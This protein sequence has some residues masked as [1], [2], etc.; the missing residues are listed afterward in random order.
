MPIDPDGGGTWIGVNSSGWTYALLNNYQG[1]IPDGKLTSRGSIVSRVLQYR[2]IE[3]IAPLLGSLPLMEFAPFSLLCLAPP[4]TPI[5]DKPEEQN[6]DGNVLRW[7][8]D[9]QRLQRAVAHR[10]LTSSSRHFDLAQQSRMTQAVDFDLL[11]QG[12]VTTRNYLTADDVRDHKRRHRAFHH[13]HAPARGAMSVCMHREDAG[14][15]SY[16]E[17]SVS[18]HRIQYDYTDSAPCCAGET[19]TI[20]LPV[21]RE[22]SSYACG[23]ADTAPVA[24]AAVPG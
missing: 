19:L 13:S 4:Q 5:S 1:Q 16:S 11:R 23:D 14:T 9:G 2:S 15:V 10:L 6:D 3:Q 22:G 24:I 17:I 21:R 7:N 20:E 18:P 12:T 8:W